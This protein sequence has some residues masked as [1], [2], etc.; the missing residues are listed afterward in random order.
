MCRVTVTRSMV[1]TRSVFGSTVTQWW[2][3][4]LWHLRW[5]CFWTWDIS[6]S[7]APK[8][9]FSKR[10]QRINQMSA[11]ILNT[12]RGWTRRSSV[13]IR[14]FGNTG[15]TL[16]TTEGS[17]IV[18]KVR[19]SSL[20]PHVFRIFNPSSATSF[21]SPAGLWT[22]LGITRYHTTREVLWTGFQRSHT[23]FY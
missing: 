11:V 19:V 17:P 18:W 8:K 20:L 2:R 22:F 7:R 10:D 16:Q 4:F 14:F 5:H 13:E 9:A 1:S 6:N 12:W 3:G 15:E 23:P 21:S